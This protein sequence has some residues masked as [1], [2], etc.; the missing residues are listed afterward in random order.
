LWFDEK[1]GIKTSQ[2]IGQVNQGLLWFD[3]KTGIKTSPPPVCTRSDALWFDEKTGIK[4][5]LGFGSL[6]NSCCGLMKKRE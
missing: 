3:E 1:T 5:S 2:T 4:T 6:R